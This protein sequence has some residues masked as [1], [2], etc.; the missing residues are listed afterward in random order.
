MARLLYS[1]TAVSVVISRRA[2]LMKQ[3]RSNVSSALI[4]ATA[5]MYLRLLVIIFFLDSTAGKSL[6]LAFAV[7]I[8]LSCLLVVGLLHPLKI[9]EMEL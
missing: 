8:I 6:L 9:L 3:D 5:M 2:R 7:L 4:M 1:S